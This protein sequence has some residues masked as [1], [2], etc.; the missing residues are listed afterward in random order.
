MNI[1][2]QMLILWPFCKEHHEIVMWIK[3]IAIVWSSAGSKQL[4]YRLLLKDVEIKSLNTD[5]IILNYF[6]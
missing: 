6:S 2:C 1:D 5:N 3:V 4:L